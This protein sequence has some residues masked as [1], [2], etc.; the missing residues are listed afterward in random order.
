MRSSLVKLCAA[1][2][3][4]A[5]TE[6]LFARLGSR[7]AGVVTAIVEPCSIEPCLISWLSLLRLCL[8]RRAHIQVAFFECE[9]SPESGGVRDG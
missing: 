7:I 3:G 5:T 2:S 8:P 1:R 9:L 4:G 6:I